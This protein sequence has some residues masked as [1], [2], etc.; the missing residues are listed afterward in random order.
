MKISTFVGVL[1]IVT[2]TYGV[3]AQAAVLGL[4]PTMLLATAMFKIAEILKERL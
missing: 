4:V 2:F 3:L 1:T